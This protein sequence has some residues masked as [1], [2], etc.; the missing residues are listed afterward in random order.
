MFLFHFILYYS[1][2]IEA[3]SV[4]EQSIAPNTGEKGLVPVRW[5]FEEVND[6]SQQVKCFNCIYVL[7]QYH[8]QCHCEMLTNI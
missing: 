4:K 2:A 5:K 1:Q 6:V 8:L 3:H 7:Y